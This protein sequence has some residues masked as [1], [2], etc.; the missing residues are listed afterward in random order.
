MEFATV[1]NKN[2]WAKKLFNGLKPEEQKQVD[3]NYQNAQKETELKQHEELEEKEKR[4]IWTME[5]NYGPMWFFHVEGK[6]GDGYLAKRFRDT[7]ITLKL[8]TSMCSTK[9]NE[10]E[11]KYLFRKVENISVSDKSNKSTPNLDFDQEEESETY[12]R[13][14]RT[15]GY[16][17]VLISPTY[18][19]GW[20]TWA[21]NSV[22]AKRIMWDANLIRFVADIEYNKEIRNKLK[23]EP[24]LVQ[25]TEED[26]SRFDNSDELE[27]AKCIAHILKWKLSEVPFIAGFRGLEV[28]L[29]PEGSLFRINE[30]DGAESI[31]TFNPEGW[32]MA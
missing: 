1:T 18:G 21:E 9:S 10:T 13:L 25:S 28:K 6:R 14:V 19:A 26:E 15:D 5:K 23:E 31:E 11:N 17:L 30:Y 8:K 3:L 20:S 12:F 16:A 22:Q 29:V 24:D 4:F 27:N 7:P 32:N 2:S